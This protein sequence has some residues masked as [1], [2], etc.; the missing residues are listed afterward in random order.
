MNRSTSMTDLERLT[1][2][3]FDERVR[4]DARPVLVKFTA[5]WCPPCHAMKPHLRAL[6]DARRD[7]SV[8]DVDTEESPQLTAT[9]GV[10]AM[11]TLILFK[12][13][14]PVAQIVGYRSRIQL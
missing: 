7:V 2:A 11:P 14:K 5:G 9:F 6:A 4:T 8:V 3:T 10:R 12:Q 13:G 1:D